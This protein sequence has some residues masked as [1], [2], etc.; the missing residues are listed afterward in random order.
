MNLALTLEIKDWFV[1]FPLRVKKKSQISLVL[2]MVKARTVLLSQTCKG[3]LNV[4]QA[5]SF[6]CTPHSSPISKSKSLGSFPAYVPFLPM[7]LCLHYPQL[8]QASW[9]FPGLLKQPLQDSIT[10]I[11]LVSN[12]SSTG[13][14]DAFQCHLI[15]LLCWGDDSVGKVHTYED[16]NSHPRNPHKIQD[17]STYL[18]PS[19]GERG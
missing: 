7:V 2:Y 19:S 6:K 1:F 3:F 18:Y 4:V 10:L 16:L 8:M 5:N 12:P 14:G 9:V 11:S 17:R 15:F 13:Q